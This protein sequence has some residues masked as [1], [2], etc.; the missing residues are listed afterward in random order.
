MSLDLRLNA[1]N[2]IDFDAGVVRL[3][4]GA[5]QVGQQ[6]RILLRTF[7]GEWFLDVTHGIPYLE[8]VHI[9][10]PNRTEIE[11]ILRKKIKEIPKVSSISKMNLQID[12]PARIFY[13]EADVETEQGLVTVKVGA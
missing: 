6:I 3:C 13:V 11:T 7:I 2:D 9:K 5:E 8:K 1:A 4:D 10:A 12:H